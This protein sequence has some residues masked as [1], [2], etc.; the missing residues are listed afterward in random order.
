[1]SDEVVG[2]MNAIFAGLYTVS[3]GADAILDMISFSFSFF[4]HPCVTGDRCVTTVI[5]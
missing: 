2:L 5:K 3:G 4:L 1:M